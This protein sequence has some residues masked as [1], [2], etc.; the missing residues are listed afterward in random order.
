M[1]TPEELLKAVQGYCERHGTELGEYKISEDGKKPIRLLGGTT[2][3][4]L[5]E[6]KITFNTSGKPKTTF[7]FDDKI[8]SIYE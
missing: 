2:D 1:R 8:T 6:A 5:I 7:K 3:W 4:I